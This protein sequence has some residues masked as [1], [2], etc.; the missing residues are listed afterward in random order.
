[1][2]K[3]EGEPRQASS[4]ADARGNANVVA[5]P[6]SGASAQPYDG[7]Y[8]GRICFAATA[9]LPKRCFNDE[10]TI[11]AGKI[12]SQWTGREQKISMDVEG[13][14]TSSGDVKVRIRQHN[15]AED[16]RLGS[17]DLTGTIHDGIIDATGSSK[18]GRDATLN[19][20]KTSAASR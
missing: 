3:N 6:A 4:S 15:D 14:V 10:G 2:P 17:F 5:A 9:D 1:M 18:R 13:S 19:W 16:T 20:H 12:S 7:G 11:S 8:A